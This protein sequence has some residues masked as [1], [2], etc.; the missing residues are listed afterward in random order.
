MGSSKLR[1]LVIL[2]SL[3]SY[4]VAMESNEHS[5]RVLVFEMPRGAPHRLVLLRWIR[6]E[7]RTRIDHGDVRC[8]LRRLIVHRQSTL[9]LDDACSNMSFWK[10]YY[11]LVLMPASL[12]ASYSLLLGEEPLYDVIL[13]VSSFFWVWAMFNR[14]VLGKKDLGQFTLLVSGVGAYLE[15]K[16]ATTVGAVLVLLNYMLAF[17]ILFKPSARTLALKA[18]ND[19]SALAMTWI[20]VFRLYICGGILF[21]ALVLCDLLDFSLPSKIDEMVEYL[22]AE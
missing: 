16:T 20:Y 18:K 7:A 8:V 19:T 6:S 13:K 2:D 21:W 12:A 15:H 10:K 14:L 1:Y 17:Y 4:G 9:D 22:R 3:P 5:A 11:G